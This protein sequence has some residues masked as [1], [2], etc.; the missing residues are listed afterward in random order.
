[1]TVASFTEEVSFTLQQ[2]V[3]CRAVSLVTYI[4]LCK[5]KDQLHAAVI[6]T[7]HT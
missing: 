7:L 3:D 6:H 5:Y 2:L 1:M 4:I